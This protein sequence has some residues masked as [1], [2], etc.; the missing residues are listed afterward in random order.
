M[1]CIPT[2]LTARDGVDL[3]GKPLEGA[4]DDT[5]KPGRDSQIQLEDVG[6]IVHG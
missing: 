4:V 3:L 5:E 1:A 2:M 6:E